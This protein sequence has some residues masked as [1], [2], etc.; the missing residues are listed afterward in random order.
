MIASFIIGLDQPFEVGDFIIVDNMQ[1]TV[2][3]VGLKTTRI[4]SLGGEILVTPNGKLVNSNI[5]NFRKML[6]RRI[7]FTMNLSYDT[8]PEKLEKF[9]QLLREA[10]EEQETARFD[11]AHFKAFGQWS[12]DYEVV[13]FVRQPDYTLYMDTQQR[14][15]LSIL[16]RCLEHDISFA[17]PTTT[18]DLGRKEMAFLG[19]T[20]SERP[21]QP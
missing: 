11:R 14:I 21:S 12:L 2:E 3:H 7:V 20:L 6:E 9:S 17:F 4:R 10:V 8:A 5:Q 19:Q 1:G 13:Y 16:R 18:L 15:N